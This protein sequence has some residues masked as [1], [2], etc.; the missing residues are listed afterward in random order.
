MVLDFI[1]AALYIGIIYV[2]G[3]W[4]GSK[5]FLRGGAES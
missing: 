2:V 1:L 4:T 3:Q 5:L